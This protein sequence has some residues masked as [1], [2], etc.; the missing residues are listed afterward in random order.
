MRPLAPRLSL[1]SCVCNT[2]ALNA[3][4]AWRRFWKNA[5]RTDASTAGGRRF[6]KPP[7]G[8][9]RFNAAVC[10]RAAAPIVFDE[11]LRTPRSGA[12][13]HALGANRQMQGNCEPVSSR[14]WLNANRNNY[15]RHW[16]ISM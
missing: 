2:F 7:K 5:N 4:Q 15:G 1:V 6:H 10:A 9:R 14:C 11:R 16:V 3:D 13:R 12:Q 8:Q